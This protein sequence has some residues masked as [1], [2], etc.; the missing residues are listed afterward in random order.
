M[1]YGSNV[2]VCAS[3]VFPILL[4]ASLKTLKAKV[5]ILVFSMDRSI[6]ELFSQRF[7]LI[8]ISLQTRA[9]GLTKQINDLY[10]QVEQA[11]MEK[12]TFS[13]L[14][15]HELRAIPKRVEVIRKCIIFTPNLNLSCCLA[16]G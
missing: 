5:Y 4:S 16:K 14:R 8:Y 11:H 3:L 12:E 1:A 13:S 15:E 10:E 7:G 2:Q 6:R 9:V